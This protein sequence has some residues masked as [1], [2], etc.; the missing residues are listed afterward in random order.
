[1][2]SIAFA[3]K[4]E[5]LPILEHDY[6]EAR[7][8][9]SREALRTKD[10]ERIPARC[11]MTFTGDV[12]RRYV[13]QAHCERI[14]DHHSETGAF[15]LYETIFEGT[16]LCLIQAPV[17]APAAAMLADRLIHSGVQAIVACGGCGVLNP[18]P[19]GKIL[20]P[21]TA[22]RDEGTSYHYV[23]PAFDIKIDAEALDVARKASER[24]GV[25]FEEC[26]IWTTDGFFRETPSIIEKRKA[27]GCS[28]VDMECAALAAVAQS[29]G[30]RFCEILYSGDSLSDPA[31]H[32]ARDWIHDESSR[33][34][35]FKL[36]LLTLSNMSI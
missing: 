6:G 10:G 18:I 27:Q 8:P 31:N 17:G 13:A 12:L 15:P 22:V 9:M 34:Q 19:S 1:M 24:S 7:N 26:R 32:N 23:K 36:A 16:P 30:I 33:T 5:L 4:N 35:A 20:L 28:A 29:Y 14:A 2:T 21:I 25:S 11:L 3:E